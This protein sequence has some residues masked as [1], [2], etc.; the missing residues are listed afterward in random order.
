MSYD[1]HIDRKLLHDLLVDALAVGGRKEVFK[2]LTDLLR[3]C[4][5]RLAVFWTDDLGGIVARILDRKPSVKTIFGN[6][7]DNLGLRCRQMW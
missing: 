6:G 7:V 4:T 2:E 3:A 5:G 1:E